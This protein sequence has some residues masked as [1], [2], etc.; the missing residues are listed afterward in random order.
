MAKNQAAASRQTE[1]T[2]TA[3]SQGDRLLTFREVNRLIGSAC[4]T[5][6]TA[7]T[8]AAR[9]QIKVVRLNERLMRFSEASVRDL[10]AGRVDPVA[11]GQVITA[12]PA[13]PADA[14]AA[15]LAEIDARADLNDVAR[16]LLRR[17]ARERAANQKG[18]PRV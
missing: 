3:T 10:V 9:G 7:R 2:T 12:A 13:P 15:E 1:A 6:H 8:L 11:R 5:S 14:L 16:H 17:E 4:K 18:A